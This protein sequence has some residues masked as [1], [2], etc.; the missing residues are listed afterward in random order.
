MAQHRTAGGGKA[1]SDH[2]RF[3]YTMR[4]AMQKL[5]ADEVTMTLSAFHEQKP[6]GSIEHAITAYAEQ[7]GDFELDDVRRGFRAARVMATVLAP[8][9]P[10][11]RVCIAE[12]WRARQELP[13]DEAFVM[14]EFPES[15]R[16]FYTKRLDTLPLYAGR[17]ED[18]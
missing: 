13:P 1:M 4:A 18:A 9:P 2:P 3:P 16:E 10:Q 5:I 7:L 17:N 14:G 8:T 15:L 6:Y 12:V 11:V